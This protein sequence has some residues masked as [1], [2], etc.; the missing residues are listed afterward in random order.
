MRFRCAG[1][2][3]VRQHRRDNS[4]RGQQ[5]V[6]HQENHNRY[7]HGI[8]KDKHHAKDCRSCGRQ[9]VG[10]EAGEA[11]EAQTPAGVQAEE[12]ELPV[13]TDAAKNSGSSSKQTEPNTD[14]PAEESV[15]ELP[16][17]PAE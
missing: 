6:R 10:N 4:R 1:E 2:N 3:G 13:L 7:C 16:F 14:A 11:E 9:P 5:A 12:G 15:I 17:V 8:Q